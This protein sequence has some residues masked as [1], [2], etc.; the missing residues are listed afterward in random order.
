M[1]IDKQR[2]TRLEAN[3]I[4]LIYLPLSRIS[5]VGGPINATVSNGVEVTIP[6]IRSDLFSN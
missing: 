4:T 2:F 1:D 5:A 3:E 6:I